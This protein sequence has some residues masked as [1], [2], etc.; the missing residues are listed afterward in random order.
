MLL[1]EVALLHSRSLAALSTDSIF[2]PSE[3]SLLQSSSQ[4]MYYTSE[5]ITMK[6]NS[7]TVVSD[8]SAANLSHVRGPDIFLKWRVLL[9]EDGNA[10]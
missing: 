7:N 10:T 6:I 1:P 8:C 5:L 2:Y 9:E 4:M 3:A